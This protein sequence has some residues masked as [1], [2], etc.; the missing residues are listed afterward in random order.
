[1]TLDQARSLLKSSREKCIQIMEK[2]MREKFEH[3][4][5]ENRLGADYDAYL[6]FSGFEAL[7]GRAPLLALETL[8]QM[9]ALAGKREKRIAAE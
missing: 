2:V 6:V 1:M 9:N 3:E 4:R 7:L 8:E 5:M